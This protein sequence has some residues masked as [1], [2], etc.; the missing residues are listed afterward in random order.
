MKWNH[1]KSPKY[2]KTIGKCNILLRLYTK[3][4]SRNT[5]FITQLLI[6]VDFK[7]TSTKL[8]VRIHSKNIFND[9]LWFKMLPIILYSGTA[10]DL[11]IILMLFFGCWKIRNTSLTSI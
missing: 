2:W 8:T 9:I 11:L 5:I 1:Y 4:F 10:V 3:L 7:L 6:T